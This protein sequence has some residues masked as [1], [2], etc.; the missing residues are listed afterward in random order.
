[1]DIA[2]RGVD[3]KHLSGSLPQLPHCASLSAP[4]C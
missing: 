4:L 1:M 3:G 2:I